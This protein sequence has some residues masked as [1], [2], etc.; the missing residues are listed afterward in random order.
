MSAE[1]DAILQKITEGI[2]KATAIGDAKMVKS[3]TKTL[4]WIKADLI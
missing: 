4:E 1:K 3:L 2:E